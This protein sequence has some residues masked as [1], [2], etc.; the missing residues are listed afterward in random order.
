MEI[1]EKFGVTV[2]LP[3]GRP[4]EQQTG[5][6]TYEAAVMAGTALVMVGGTF[7]VEKRFVAVADGTAAA[8]AQANED[9]IGLPGTAMEPPAS[10]IEPEATEPQPEVVSE[11]TE[12]VTDDSGYVDF[13]DANAVDGDALPEVAGDFVP[14]IPANTE[15]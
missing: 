2:Y 3:N 7:V 1:A 10:L 8:V 6:A 15:V 4:G 12:P 14:E 5:L 11:V 13:S 9:G